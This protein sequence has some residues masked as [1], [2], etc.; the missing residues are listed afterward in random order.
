MILNGN[1]SYS[2]DEEYFKLHKKDQ[3]LEIAMACGASIGKQFSKLKRKDLIAELVKYY[4]NNEPL[5]NEHQEQLKQS[6]CPRL[7]QFEAE[8]SEA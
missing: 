4:A 7:M 6:Y 2:P 8:K 1:G 3:L 5:K